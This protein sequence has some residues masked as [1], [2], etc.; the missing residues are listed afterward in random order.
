MQVCSLKF[1]KANDNKNGNTDTRWQSLSKNR[2]GK[3]LYG[4]CVHV[5]WE[6]RQ[7]KIMNN[8][9]IKKRLGDMHWYLKEPLIYRKATATN[10][11]AL[12]KSNKMVTVPSSPELQS[13]QIQSH[14]NR[15]IHYILTRKIKQENISL[16]THFIKYQWCACILFHFP[17]KVKR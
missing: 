4:M 16:C 15:C 17:F 2:Q 12:K 3:N 9:L 13:S 8:N 10:L 5:S 1:L 7:L 6:D 11:I 14:N